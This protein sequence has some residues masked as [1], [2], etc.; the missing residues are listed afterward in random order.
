MTDTKKP[1]SARESCKI[2]RR[3]A[4]MRETDAPATYKVRDPKTG[5]VIIGRFDVMC[6]LCPTVKPTTLRQRLAKGQRDLTILRAKPTVPGRK[7]K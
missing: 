7:M 3:V 4:P 5:E 2:N 6:A 1:I